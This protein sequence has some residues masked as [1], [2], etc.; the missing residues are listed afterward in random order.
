MGKS[1]FAT[2]HRHLQ[3][4]HIIVIVRLHCQE[5]SW[6][7]T[8]YQFLYRVRISPLCRCGF[9]SP[10]YLWFPTNWILINVSVNRVCICTLIIVL[11]YQELLTKLFYSSR[12]YLISAFLLSRNPTPDLSLGFRWTPTSISKDPYLAIT[13]SPEM[14]TLDN[15]KVLLHSS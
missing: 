1:N 10:R 13:S 7:R 14:K 15:C 3:T 8:N 9:M 12:E 6:V 2:S 11:P 4:M 5:L